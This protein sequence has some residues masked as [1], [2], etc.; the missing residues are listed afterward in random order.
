MPQTGQQLLD[1]IHGQNGQTI[2]GQFSVVAGASSILMASNHMAAAAGTR[3]PLRGA[4]GPITPARVGSVMRT[5]GLLT[6]QHSGATSGVDMSAFNSPRPKEQSAF[7]TP[8]A[9]A[10]HDQASKSN[11][12]M[13]T[14]GGPGL[15]YGASQIPRQTANNGLLSELGGY[16]NTTPPRQVDQERQT[17][18]GGPAS[19]QRQSVPA[20][21]QGQPPLHF[22]FG[23]NNQNGIATTWSEMLPGA[24]QATGVTTVANGNF[25]TP[26]IMKSMQEFEQLKAQ[27][28]PMAKAF[29]A[30]PRKSNMAAGQQTPRRNVVAQVSE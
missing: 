10:H 2:Q 25:S 24:R 16:I 28:L 30:S 19:G 20:A 14:F 15:H 27:G 11:S 3:L 4:I 12:G 8:T 13:A 17:T 7:Q 26:A 9:L 21:Q 23:N 5:P 18:L 1:T 6:P 29:K 22:A